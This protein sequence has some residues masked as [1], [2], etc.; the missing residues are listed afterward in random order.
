MR[1]PGKLHLGALIVVLGTTA[2]GL[3]QSAKPEPTPTPA[4]P[5]I[6]LLLTSLVPDATIEIAGET[7]FASGPDGVWISS[8][9]TGT[10]VRID[11]KTNKP[12][13]PVS[14]GNEPCQSLVF[15]FKS[16]WSPICA[17]GALRRVTPTDPDKPV[18]ITTAVR[19]AGPLVAATGSI[20]MITDAAGSLVRIDPDTNAVVAEVTIAN[21]ATALAVSGDTLWVASKT[22]AMVS[23][24]NGH[25]NVVEETVKVG[26]SPLAV[27]SG[28]GSFWVLN[29]DGSVSRIDPKTNKVIETIKTG[30]AGTTGTIAVGEGSVW[31][32][33]PGFPLSRIDP[34]TNRLAQ[35]FTGPGGGV[36]LIAQKSIW[37]NATPTH[38]WRVDPK[39]VEATRK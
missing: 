8:R 6:K 33:T 22:K 14:I 28:E 39:R 18:T 16:L 26:A 11:P 24:V 37:L 30:A 25:T 5:P 27:A 20:W 36:F 38:V 7:S 35:Q 31:L 3:A 17:G 21:G 12:E 1:L 34:K 23:R 13:K 9:T 29:S 15:A 32:S 10:A 2:A 4:A 19:G